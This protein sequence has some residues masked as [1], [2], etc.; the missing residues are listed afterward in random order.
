[1]EGVVCTFAVGSPDGPRSGTYRLS[2]TQDGNALQLSA[3]PG[4]SRFTATIPAPWPERS[5][6]S[7]DERRLTRES[8]RKAIA[9]GTWAAGDAFVAG[10]AGSEISP[11]V[12]ER[13]SVC[14]P[15]S[16]LRAFAE[17]PDGP[18]PTWIT[19]PPEFGQVNVSVLVGAGSTDT[20]PEARAI[21]GRRAL[22][23][24]LEV[25]A[26]CSIEQAPS[27]LQKA[28]LFGAIRKRQPP[29]V[30]QGVLAL[31]STRLV[32][33]WQLDGRGIFTEIAG[34]MFFT[35]GSC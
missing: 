17:A 6:R 24:G 25:V 28:G 21:L 12:C 3:R 13:F 16:A 31:P 4:A 35:P 23:N 7:G 26:A 34:D 1:M 18:E 8:L 30:P 32:L 29:E 15:A 9:A 27:R 2:T 19:S 14:F 10:W 20:Q 22:S 5:G 33:I 11:G